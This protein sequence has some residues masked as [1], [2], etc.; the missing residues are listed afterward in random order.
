C[1]PRER[2]TRVSLL[3]SASDRK[4]RVQ[5]NTMSKTD[6]GES[7]THATCLSRWCNSSTKRA[8]DFTVALL[9]LAPLIPVMIVIAALVAL[10]SP[11]PVLFRQ[12]RPGKNGIPF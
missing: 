9:M 1:G 2:H 3:R 8:F 11:G 10:T 5:E 6:L 12:K 4:Q 7:S